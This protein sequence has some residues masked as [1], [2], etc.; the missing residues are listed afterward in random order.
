MDLLKDVKKYRGQNFTWEYQLDVETTEGRRRSAT[1]ISSDS[2]FHS[3]PSGKIEIDRRRRPDL[4]KKV[5]QTLDDM[6][7]VS[8][9]FLNSLYR[10]MT[11]F[12]VQLKRD[13]PLLYDDLRRRRARWVISGLTIEVT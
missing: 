12:I 10:D 8:N 2:Y 4:S 11:G 9:E 6:A 1:K 13:Y 3:K 7:S 5:E